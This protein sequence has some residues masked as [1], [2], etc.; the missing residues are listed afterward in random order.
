MS[1][2]YSDYTRKIVHV[3]ED[4]PVIQV[5][6]Q[7]IL[8]VFTVAF[9]IFFAIRPTLQTIVTLQKKIKDQQSV[10]LKLD[11]K[12]TQLVEAQDQLAL[13]AGDLP[14]VERGV[15]RDSEIKKLTAMVEAEANKNNV[16]MVGL[17]VQKYP[18]WQSQ[19]SG[20][21]EKFVTFN[22]NVGGTQADLV[23][24][25]AAI[26]NMERLVGMTQVSFSKPTGPEKD[27]YPLTA[28]VKGTVYYQGNITANA[29]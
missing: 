27:L 6:L 4:E 29:K 22:V 24:F 18:V 10:N 15:P 26:E 14:L 2:T 1:Q 11:T 5:S 3:Y 25:L 8:S 17:E 7:L 16:W 28:L 23:R 19:A 20:K 13:Y 21:A 9:F 12:L